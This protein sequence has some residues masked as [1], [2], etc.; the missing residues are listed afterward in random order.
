M[1]FWKLSR[2]L[3]CLEGGKSVL[4]QFVLQENTRWPAELHP[5]HVC[6][7]YM[8]FPWGQLCS[9]PTG[10]LGQESYFWCT[11]WCHT[12]FLIL[13][14]W[15]KFSSRDSPQFSCCS[16][17]GGRG[18]ETTDV[19]RRTGRSGWAALVGLSVASLSLIQWCVSRWQMLLNPPWP[20]ELW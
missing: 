15:V 13:C 11:Q 3:Q 1:E 14:A 8:T 17:R 2:L 5:Y 20:T 4:L 12:R 6:V 9:W 7:Q 16:R 19:E 10:F 18:V